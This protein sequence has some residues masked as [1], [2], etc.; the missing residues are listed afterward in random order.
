MENRKS[1]YRFQ[2]LSK[3]NPG[4]NPDDGPKRLTLSGRIMIKG[5]RDK[6]KFCLYEGHYYATRF[7]G[8]S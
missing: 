4:S 3:S 6:G 5:Y 1:Y 8:G 7:K 2:G